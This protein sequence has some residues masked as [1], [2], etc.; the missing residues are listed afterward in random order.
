MVISTETDFPNAPSSSNTIFNDENFQ[1]LRQHLVYFQSDLQTANHTRDKVSW[2]LVWL[3][4]QQF[5]GTVMCVAMLSESLL[6]KYNVDFR[7]REHVHSYE[8]PHPID[9]TENP[10]AVHEWK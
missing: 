5:H 9:A 8:R 7:F 2:F 6:V 10:V 4:F 1:E 3:S